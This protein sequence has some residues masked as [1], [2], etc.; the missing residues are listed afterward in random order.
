MAQRVALS[1]TTSSP[2][3]HDRLGVA[4]VQRGQPATVTGHASS[5]PSCDRCARSSTTARP[6]TTVAATVSV[7]A[8][9]AASEDLF[10]LMNC[11]NLPP[12]QL[13]GTVEAGD[14]GI[15]S[16]LFRLVS[17]PL[18]RLVHPFTLCPHARSSGQAYSWWYILTAE[19][20]ATA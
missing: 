19:W 11:C 16:S 20:L 9:S 14:H 1:P 18:Q 7:W 17:H 10:R 4:S 8:R 2:G 13:H 6:P 12:H 5:R 15:S 3:A